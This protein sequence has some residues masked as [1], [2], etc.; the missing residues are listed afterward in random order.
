MPTMGVPSA[1]SMMTH[2]FFGFCT[3]DGG[4]AGGGSMDSIE[5]AV[6]RPPVQE[7]AQEHLPVYMSHATAE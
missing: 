4:M 2:A 1:A 6:R 3:G 7:Q 5:G